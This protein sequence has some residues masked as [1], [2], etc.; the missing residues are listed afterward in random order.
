M[1]FQLDMGRIYTVSRIL[2]GDD[3]E[4][5]SIYVSDY[6]RK[7][8]VEVSKDG[9]IWKKVASGEGHLDEYVSVSFEPTQARFIRITQEGYCTPEWW[10]I[11]EIHVYKPKK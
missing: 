4:G 11:Y 5:V 3:G 9:S 7:Y 6:P 10:T 2:L 1:Y 8:V